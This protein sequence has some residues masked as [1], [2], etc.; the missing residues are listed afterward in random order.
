[1]SAP[2]PVLR[3]LRRRARQAEGSALAL[4]LMAALGLMVAVGDLAAHAGGRQL[5]D[6]VRRWLGNPPIA[7]GGVR[8]EPPRTVCL[9]HPWLPPDATPPLALV[10]LPRP[11]LSTATPIS[12]ISLEDSSGRFLGTEDPAPAATPGS[13]MPWPTTWPSLQPGRRYRL[14]L[15]PAQTAQTAALILQT[16]SEEDFRQT[17][18]QLRQLGRDPRDW[19]RAIAA[20]LEAAAA[21]SDTSRAW[22]ASLLFAPAA[23]SSASLRR[24]RQSLQDAHCAGPRG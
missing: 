24:M 12:R 9:L 16:G 15:K 6:W 17:L 8:G 19:E 20:H 22:A 13:L 18:D 7:A 1:M 3:P 21:P 5:V 14:L 11:A 2:E 23:P 10:L 4:R